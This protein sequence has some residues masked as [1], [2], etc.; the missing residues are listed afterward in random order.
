MRS[1]SSSVW[2]LELHII[3]S[4]A[5]GASPADMKRILKLSGAVLGFP[6]RCSINPA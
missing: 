6:R 4:E 2:L 1:R 3:E 5:G